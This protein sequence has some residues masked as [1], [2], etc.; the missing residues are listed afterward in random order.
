MPLEFNR[1]TAGQ[2]IGDALDILECAH[3]TAFG[4]GDGSPAMISWRVALQALKLRNMGLS[5]TDFV[6]KE[7]LDAWANIVGAKAKWRIGVQIA[8]NETHTNRV[9]EGLYACCNPT[10]GFWVAAPCVNVVSASLQTPQVLLEPDLVIRDRTTA[11]RCDAK[12]LC[13]C[14]IGWQEYPVFRDMNIE[15]PL[16]CQHLQKWAS[17]KRPLL[18]GMMILKNRSVA[19]HEAGS[20]LL[21]VTALLDVRGVDKPQAVGIGVG[22]D[23]CGSSRI[24]EEPI[25][26]NRVV[27]RGLE[28][29]C[30]TQPVMLK[31]DACAT[32]QIVKLTVDELF[33]S[34]DGE[35]GSRLVQCVNLLD[36]VTEVVAPPLR[37]IGE[38]V[39][40]F[41]K[42]KG[43]GI[44]R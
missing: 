22:S 42:S 25:A 32:S 3:Y 37:S 17:F 15:F 31:R 4:V 44:D 12:C 39:V 33:A 21:S 14:R 16:S 38:A 27:I 18:D 13:E 43:F 20:L 1:T 24:L 23:T 40:Y 5:I 36:H 11:M 29:M 8:I 34:L 28:N 41:R 10:Q 9:A 26:E 2:R 35:Y 30:G 6:A 7:I 19:R